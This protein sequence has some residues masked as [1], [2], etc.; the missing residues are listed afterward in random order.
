[1]PGYFLTRCSFF[2]LRYKAPLAFPQTFSLYFYSYTILPDSLS[3]FGFKWLLARMRWSRA[4]GLPSVRIT[5]LSCECKHA[6]CLPQP[7]I[8]TET[9]YTVCHFRHN[10]RSQT[11]AVTASRNLLLHQK[12]FIS[13]KLCLKYLHQHWVHMAVMVVRRISI[14]FPFLLTILLL[15]HAYNEDAER[16]SPADKRFQKQ[17]TGTRLRASHNTSI[18]LCLTQVDR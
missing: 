6:P 12:R 15:V 18:R 5:N 9:K 17:T 11:S 8:T 3:L 7:A 14:F 10:D 16:V 2:P 1:L 13:G 4:P